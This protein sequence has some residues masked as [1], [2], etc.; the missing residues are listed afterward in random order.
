MT[1]N[2]NTR[3]LVSWCKKYIYF[4]NEQNQI[5]NVELMNAAYGSSE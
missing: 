2:D 4:N 1:Y 5:S 3:L